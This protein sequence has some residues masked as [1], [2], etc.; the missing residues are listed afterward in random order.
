MDPAVDGFLSFSGKVFAVLIY[1]LEMRDVDTGV[2]VDSLW[3]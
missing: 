1:Y 3:M 2:V